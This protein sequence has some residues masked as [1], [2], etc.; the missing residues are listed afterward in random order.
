MCGAEPGASCTVISGF[1][2]EG[3]RPGD[4]RPTPHFYRSP[5]LKQRP[6]VLVKDEP[7]F[8]DAL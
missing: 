5:T 8:A 1:G 3:D 6:A 7:P 4:E 2:V